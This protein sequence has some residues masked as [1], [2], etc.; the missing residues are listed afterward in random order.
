LEKLHL[1]GAGLLSFSIP[2]TAVSLLILENIPLT[3][4]GIGLI[5]LAASILLTPTR[6]VPPQ[7]VRAMLESSILSLEEIL[8]EFEI[9]KRGYYVRAPDG[10]VYLYVPLREDAGPP[11][12]R[13]EPV[14][15]VHRES[16]VEYLV[17]VPPA[18]E[19]VKSPE[20]SGTGFE[21]ALT[22]VLIDLLE[23]ADSLEVVTDGFI[24]VKLRNVKSHV[25]AGRFKAVFGSLEASIAAC[26]AASLL[27]PTRVAEELEEG[28][29]KTIIL[30]VLGG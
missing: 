16:G 1:F 30:E 15:L 21:P 20:V 22:Y 29:D 10:R 3:A 9:S 13:E 14:G 19:L 27:G 4:L 2:F 8:E 18:A 23:A 25:S 24:T 6:S 5:I 11:S 28:D 26:I 7:A 17:L 12:C